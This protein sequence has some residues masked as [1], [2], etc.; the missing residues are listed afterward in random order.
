MHVT[1]SDFNLQVKRSVR[2]IVDAR[3]FIDDSLR[4]RSGGRAKAFE[5]ITIEQPEVAP[6]IHAF[7][8]SV[9]W[10]FVHYNDAGR[11]TVRFLSERARNL[12]L[13]T[14]G[15]IVRHVKDV[16]VLRTVL[17]HNLD[18]SNREDSI[19]RKSFD[20]W[21][22]YRLGDLTIKGASLPHKESEWIQLTIALLD[23]AATS[24]ERMVK[25]TTAIFADEFSQDVVDLWVIRANRSLAAHVWDRIIVQEAANL[26]FEGVSP[27]AIR[28]K[29]ISAWQNQLRQVA[30]ID[31]KRDA[32]RIVSLTLIENE[33]CFCP[34]GGGDIIRLLGV[35]KGPMVAELLREAKSMFKR[36]M[37]DTEQI[38][39]ELRKVLG[40]RMR[41]D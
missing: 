8:L 37:R 41:L 26:G 14:A 30:S 2:R 18:T 38:L 10:L 40:N 1:K 21:I 27:Q 12:S 33:D 19:C 3:D 31:P 15:D 32:E 7:Y 11:E 35:P 29:H 16:N 23:E 25:A 22:G 20:Y 34:L 6:A 36:G 24:F 39:L 13:D 9:S 28:G 17:Q 5:A 4:S